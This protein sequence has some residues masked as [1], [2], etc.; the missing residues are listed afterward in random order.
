MEIHGFDATVTGTT[1]GTTAKSSGE[2]LVT[3]SGT[4]GK[5]QRQKK[6]RKNGDITWLTE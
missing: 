1:D 5:D 4:A 6:G 2:D 3:G